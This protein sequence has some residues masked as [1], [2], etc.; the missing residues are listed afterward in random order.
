M[1]IPPTVVITGASAGLGRAIA[2]EFARKGARVGLIARDEDAL[3]KTAEEVEELGG[4]AMVQALDVSDDG[5]VELR[6]CR[7]T[8]GGGA[9]GLVGASHL[10]A[11]IQY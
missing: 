8:T 3:Q 11:G 2:H 9:S 6:P 10:C 1:Q 5:A 4:E 7:R